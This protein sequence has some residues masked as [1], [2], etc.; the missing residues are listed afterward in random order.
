M[1]LEGRTALVTGGGRGIGAAVSKRLAADGARV[2][3][4]YGTHAA[5]AED[6][7]AAARSAGGRHDRGIVRSGRPGSRGA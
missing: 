1:R 3:V 6:T 5:A 7:A 4:H 2:L